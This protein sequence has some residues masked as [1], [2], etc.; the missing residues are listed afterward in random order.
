MAAPIA[1][2][3][4]GDGSGGHAAGSAAV[5]TGAASPAP[6]DPDAGEAGSGGDD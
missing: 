4:A 3:A 1:A 5:V 2:P 6:V